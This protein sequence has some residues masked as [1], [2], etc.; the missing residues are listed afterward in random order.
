[1][2]LSSSR[3]VSLECTFAN[4]EMS[5]H[6]TVETQNAILMT[7]ISPR[8]PSRNARNPRSLLVKHHI[9]V[10][11]DSPSDQVAAVEVHWVERVL[12]RHPIRRGDNGSPPSSRRRRR[13]GRK[14]PP[15][16]TDT[17]CPCPRSGPRCQRRERLQCDVLGT[18]YTVEDV[19]RANSPGP[20]FQTRTS[21]TALTTEAATSQVRPCTRCDSAEDRNNGEPS[22]NWEASPA[23]P[24][25]HPR[26][27][28]KILFA[29][30]AVSTPF[31]HLQWSRSTTPGRD[32]EVTYASERSAY[33]NVF[34][35][36]LPERSRICGRDGSSPWALTNATFD[37]TSR[38]T[39]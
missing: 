24:R 15:H 1:M 16:M 14:P 39:R 37:P 29:D 19:D 6:T 34:Y 35:T 26:A 22:Q 28:P 8:R 27:W 9:H 10:L 4:F 21:G 11:Q 7:N 13:A 18:R 12:V 30:A 23:T 31:F 32:S 36:G 20:P 17:E 3:A 33:L 25:T 5:R 38:R 2:Q